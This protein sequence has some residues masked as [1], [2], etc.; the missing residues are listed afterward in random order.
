[1]AAPNQPWV[2][3]IR[4][5][6]MAGDDIGNPPA[7]RRNPIPIS[8]SALDDSPNISGNLHHHV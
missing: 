7:M 5:P 4:K 8:N 2:K 6:N 3:F 1:M